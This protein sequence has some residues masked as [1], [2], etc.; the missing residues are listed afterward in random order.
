MARSR[1]FIPGVV[2]PKR[3]ARRGKRLLVVSTVSALG[4]Y[5][6]D[7]Q[8]GTRRRHMAR[9]RALR[10][11][12]R[13]G[14]Q[15]AGQARYAG[16]R[17]AGTAH[18]LG[19]KVTPDRTTAEPMNDQT[20]IRK[21]ETEIFRD[22]EVPKADI[23]VD[24]AG[25]TIWLRGQARTPEM[26]EELERRTQSVPEVLRVE[27]LLRLPGT[28]GPTRADSPEG[29]REGALFPNAGERSVA[30]LGVT[31]EEPVAEAEPPPDEKAVGGKGRTPAPFG[32][33]GSAGS[34]TPPEGG[35][36]PEQDQS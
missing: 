25:G 4:V 27:N 7:P 35:A 32:S 21:V 2:P 23:T 36:G 19:Q 33:E 29:V 17:A 31:G 3:P 11:L 28:P 18:E 22:P 24:A 12:R 8:E 14:K 34:E 10:L 16:G 6:F 1:R 13:G 20:L 26:I 9:D 30:T 15:A 5:F